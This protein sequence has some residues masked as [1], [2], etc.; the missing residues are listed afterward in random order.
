MKILHIEARTNVDITQVI[1]KVKFKGKLGLLTTIQLV[2]QLKNIQKLLPNS[3]I[4]GQ[5][6]GCNASLAKNIDNKV[7][8]FLYI[9]SGEFH[10]LEVA[11]ET[12][13][14]VFWANPF[15]NEVKEIPKAD[16]EKRKKRMK[17]A[18]LKFL[19][20]KKI[21]ILVS[22]KEGQNQIKKAKAF[23]KTLKDKDS[24]IFL[25]NTLNFIDL[26][27]FPDIDCW[28]NTACSRIA[29]EDYKKFNKPVINLADLERLMNQ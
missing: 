11:L 20:S 18:Y 4:G 26:E 15:T 27:N 5:I 24:Y 6:L 7:D 2:G 12:S 28:I 9:G 17:G 1:K 13:K 14:P 25:F 23:Q 3:I 29:I 19:T 21:G 8:A 16:I 10:P 22:T